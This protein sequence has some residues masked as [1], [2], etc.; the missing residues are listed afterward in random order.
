MKEQ[1]RAVIR[2][3]PN[4]RILQ[5]HW[6]SASLLSFA[7]LAL[8]FSLGC[9]KE[10]QEEPTVS[11]QVTAVEK[12]T[13]QRTVSAEAI[14]FPLQQSAIVPKISAPVKKFY[15][16]RGRPVRQGQL[17]AVLENRDLSAAQQDT[18]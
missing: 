4:P 8:I 11:V 18:K 3:H 15:V 12:K 2:N 1:P 6:I 17:L 7:A 14:L 16:M 10:K 13:I 9:S 5:T